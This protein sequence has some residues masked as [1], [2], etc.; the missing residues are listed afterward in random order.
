MDKVWRQLSNGEDKSR[1]IKIAHNN[2]PKTQH[3][4]PRRWLWW[5]CKGPHPQFSVRVVKHSRLDIKRTCLVSSTVE[6]TLLLLASCFGVDVWCTAPTNVPYSFFCK[7]GGV[8]TLS[9]FVCIG[10]PANLRVLCAIQRDEATL[11]KEGI[12]N[13]RCRLTSGK[14]RC[15]IVTTVW[16]RV[17]LCAYC[18]VCVRVYA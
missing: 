11:V 10:S 18:C 8:E 7:E 15:R 4:G 6:C 14:V 17:L 16:V 5:H 1:N 2:D 9:C 3:F 13:H 12:T